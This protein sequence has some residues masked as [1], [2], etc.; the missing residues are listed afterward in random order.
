MHNIE[1]ISDGRIIW[2]P[3]NDAVLIF[4]DTR[5]AMVQHLMVFD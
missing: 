2:R 1:V 3:L 5:S 4:I